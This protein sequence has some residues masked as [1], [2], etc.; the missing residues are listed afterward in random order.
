M[1]KNSIVLFL[2]FLA[3]CKEKNAFLPI[4]M[5]EGVHY[6]I[7]FVNKEKKEKFFK[8]SYYLMNHN[9][10]KYSFIR[11]DGKVINYEK[12]DN[13]LFLN[14]TKYVYNSFVDLPEEKLFFEK[15]NVL[16]KFPLNVGQEWNTQDQTTLVM[17]LGYDRIYQTHLPV[18]IKNKI[19]ETDVSLKVDRKVLKDCILIE[20]EG[21][22]SYNPGPPL[23]SININI[24]EK[25]WYSPQYGLVKLIREENS[26][27]QTMGNIYYE[28]KLS[29]K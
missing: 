18:N 1:I 9:K 8:Q 12:K 6:D 10:N 7:K 2:V 15:K 17:K 13:I 19:V 25:L 27:S 16:L 24:K 11:N 21:S 28:K 4:Y 3:S 29:T 14:D 26:N 22:T 23:E 5:S 20:S